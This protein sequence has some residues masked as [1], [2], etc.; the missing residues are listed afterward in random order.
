MSR[1]SEMKWSWEFNEF[2]DELFEK[3]NPNRKDQDISS[4]GCIYELIDE[5]QEN[6]NEYSGD[7]KDRM[8]RKLLRHIQTML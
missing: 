2:M 3:Y 5:F 6:L 1:V 8:Y 4:Q 7:R